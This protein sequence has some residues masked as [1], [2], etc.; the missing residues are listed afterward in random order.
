MKQLSDEDYL[1]FNKI[2]QIREEIKTKNLEVN[3]LDFGAGNPID[4]R[5]NETMSKGVSTVKNTSELCGI[6]L[7]KNWAQLIYTLVK[8]H[9]P[10]KILE[11]GTCCGF[12]SIYMASANPESIVYTIEGAPEVA[13]IAASNI[14]K[15]MCNNIIQKVGKFNDILPDLLVELNKINLVFIDGHHDKEATIKYYKDIK[16]FLAKDAIV[17]FDDISWSDG[18]K[19]AWNTIIEDSTIKKFENLEKLGICYL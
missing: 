11:L 3:F 2:E 9:K 7:K 8:I 19:E 5:D 17:I 10:K 6:G 15:S 16:P 18:M 4:T 14:K 1:I 13:K 12:S